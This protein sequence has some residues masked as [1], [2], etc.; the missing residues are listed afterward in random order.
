MNLNLKTY[1]RINIAKSTSRVYSGTLWHLKVNSY[2][3]SFTGNSWS[4]TLK[5]S[6]ESVKDCIENCEYI[7]NRSPWADILGMLCQ[8][9]R[10]KHNSLIFYLVRRKDA[11]KSYSNEGYTFLLHDTDKVSKNFLWLSVAYSSG[12]SLWDI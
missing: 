2:K 7:F 11:T 4:L 3:A 1:T 12:R 9:K 5:F 10:S 6:I 8:E